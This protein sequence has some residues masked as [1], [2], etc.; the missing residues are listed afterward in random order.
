MKIIIEFDPGEL[1]K[2]AAQT[3]TAAAGQPGASAPMASPDM[4]VATAAVGAID[5]GPGP[6][7]PCPRYRR[8][9]PRRRA[10]GA[11]SAGPAPNLP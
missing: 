3:V 6:A 8:N 7:L 4:V 5:A 2:G 1:A 10:V 9:L 11:I